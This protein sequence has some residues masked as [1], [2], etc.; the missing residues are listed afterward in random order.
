[1]VS[2]ILSYIDMVRTTCMLSTYF[3]KELTSCSCFILFHMQMHENNA[4]C[5]QIHLRAN[6]RC[7]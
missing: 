2:E 4:S 1:M 6:L 3:C 5:S 7:S